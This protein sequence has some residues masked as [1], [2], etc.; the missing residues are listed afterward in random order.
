MDRPLVRY[1]RHDDTV[2]LTLSSAENRNTMTAAMR[3]ALYEGL[4]NVV[5]DPSVPQLILRGEGRCFSTGGH[6]AEFGSAQD[7]AAAH[8]IRSLRSCARLLYALEKRSEVRLQGACIGSGIE[9][10]AAAGRRIAAPDSY[11]QLPELRM[12]LIPGAG[13]TVTLPRAIGRHRAAW[14][15]LGAFRIGVRQAREWGLVHSVAT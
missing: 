12:G 11:F 4:A 14:M 9:I 10:A 2:T 1:D 6:L 3:D 8:V 15:A 7:L 5:E 13:G